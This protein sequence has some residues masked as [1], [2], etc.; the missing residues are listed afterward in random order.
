[1]QP[2]EIIQTKQWHELTNGERLII[3]ELAANEQEFNLM[4]KIISVSLEE[5]SE[6]PLVDPIVHRN[7]RNNFKQVKQKR[8]SRTRMI[9]YAAAM[10]LVL[11]VATIFL[12]QKNEAP[13]SSE[14]VIT[15]PPI[16]TSPVD[17]L[18]KNIP[19]AQQEPVV[20]VPSTPKKKITN[21]RILNSSQSDKDLLAINN[22]I[23]DEPE[24]LSLITELN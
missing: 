13:G 14:I 9:W 16:S 15:N 2:E 10:I 11:L 6:V 21:E 5:S 18:D 19:S 20:I 17:S 7:L 24:L 1:M 8:G 23:S 12:R 3:E 22:R 4:K